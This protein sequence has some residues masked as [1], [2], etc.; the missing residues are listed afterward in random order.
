M[1]RALSTTALAGPGQPQQK[2]TA[3]ALRAK[4]TELAYSLQHDEA[5]A[6]LRRAVREPNYDPASEVSDLLERIS[7]RT[8]HPRWLIE[9]WAK[10]FGVEETRVFAEANNLVPPTAFRVVNVRGNE[11]EV[12]SK[13][14]EAGATVEKSQVAQGAWRVSGATSLVR[15]L[16]AVS[17]VRA[18]SS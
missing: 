12:L 4:A 15:E 7:I 2:E 3:E 8:S 10:S 13:L 6:L 11:A 1:P 16:T 9:R 14:T 5:V 18:W 17:G